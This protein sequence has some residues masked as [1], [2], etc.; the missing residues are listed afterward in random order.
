MLSI[1][2]AELRPCIPPVTIS[3]KNLIGKTFGT[4]TRSILL[5]TESYKYLR[6]ISNIMKHS[7][8]AKFYTNLF[9]KNIE[10]PLY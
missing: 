5:G 1:E 4:F 3:R 2:V 7:L 9:S 6:K 8:N 10:F